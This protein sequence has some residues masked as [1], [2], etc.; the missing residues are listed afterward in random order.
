MEGNW[1]IKVWRGIGECRY[2]EELENEVM[3]GNWRMK[4]WRGT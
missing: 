3:E 4:A 2:G 1:R